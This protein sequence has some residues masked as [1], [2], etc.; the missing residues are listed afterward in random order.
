MNKLIVP[1]LVSTPIYAYI[2]AVGS[3]TPDGEEGAI[4]HT[5]HIF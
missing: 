1:T 2:G 4:L 5:V 3:Q